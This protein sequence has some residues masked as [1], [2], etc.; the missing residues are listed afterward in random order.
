MW[1]KGKSLDWKDEIRPLFGST[2]AKEKDWGGRISLSPTISYALSEGKEVI[3]WPPLIYI[4]P[5]ICVFILFCYIIPNNFFFIRRYQSW[6]VIT[7]LLSLSFPFP[8]IIS[9]KALKNLECTDSQV[10]GELSFLSNVGIENA[11]LEIQ[12]CLFGR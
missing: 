12:V 4:N 7:L 3:L 2:F 8:S 5:F 9:I 11:K 1:R 6:R 10:L